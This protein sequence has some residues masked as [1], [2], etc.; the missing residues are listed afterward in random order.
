[1][2]RFAAR[3]RP[4]FARRNLVAPICHQLK[5]RLDYRQLFGRVI[6][7]VEAWVRFFLFRRVEVDRLDAGAVKNSYGAD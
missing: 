7:R 3:F 2:A 4:D 6:S 1:M 5:R